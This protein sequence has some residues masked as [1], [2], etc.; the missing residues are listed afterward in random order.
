[1]NCIEESDKETWQDYEEKV[2]MAVREKLGMDI[3]IERA[4]RVEKRGGKAKKKGPRTMVCRLRD[5][6]QREERAEEKIVLMSIRI[7]RIDL[8]E[9]FLFC[10]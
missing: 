7:I 4:H 10:T 5:C 9:I 1:M 2:K 6:K 8:V 3:T